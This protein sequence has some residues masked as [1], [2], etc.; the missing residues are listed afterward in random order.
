MTERGPA[1]TEEACRTSPRSRV[2]SIDLDVFVDPPV[3]N[4]KDNDPRPDEDGY[5][6]TEASAVEDFLRRCGLNPAFPARGFVIEHHVE[7]FHRLREMIDNGS[8]TAPFDLVH[9]DAHAD[10]AAGFSF[11]PQ[12]IMTYALHRPLAERVR[13]AAAEA[14]SADWL[15]WAVACCWLRSIVHVRRDANSAWA[16]RDY[17]DCWFRDGDPASGIIEMAAYAPPEGWSLDAR[18][19]HTEPRVEFSTCDLGTYRASSRFDLVAVCHS[20]AFVPPTG[21]VLLPILK[22]V[23]QSM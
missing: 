15:A 17:L 3:L 18:P 23:V 19:T 8:L 5:R 9:A 7:L 4:V 12:R 13:L 1:L 14:S 6:I 21:D 20:P 10:M 2:L 11:A 22:S 16:R